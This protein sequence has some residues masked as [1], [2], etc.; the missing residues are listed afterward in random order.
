MSKHL[1]V[2]T[3]L[4]MVVWMAFWSWY[5]SGEYL[6][7][8]NRS[9]RQAPVFQLQHGSINYA[10][11]EVLSFRPSSALP[12]LNPEHHR[13]FIAISGYLR[14]HPDELLHL[15]GLCASFER[16]GTSFEALGL[17]R[18]EAV[19]GFLVAAGAPPS[20]ILTE[21]VQV[22]NLLSVEGQLYGTVL[23]SFSGLATEGSASLSAWHLLQTEIYELHFPEGRFEL[24]ESIEKAQ[25]L[26]DSLILAL[27]AAP[28]AWVQLTGYSNSREQDN[29]L[30]NLAE[31][32]ARAVRQYLL[33]HGLDRKKVEMRYV[34]HQ[35]PSSKRSKVELKV[36]Q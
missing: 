29:S 9:H 5:L 1:S 17:A 32:R 16:N 12:Q 11:Q 30:Y 27:K 2:A 10:G 19:K 23:F 31:L 33:T 4:A 8:Y 24:Q 21:S 34:L 7:Y 15:S 35:S 14:T 36:V 3:I 13:F 22:D 26:L 25:P 20:R 18:A 28:G 6:Y